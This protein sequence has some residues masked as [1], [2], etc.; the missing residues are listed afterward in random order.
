MNDTFKVQKKLRLRI[1]ES[2]PEIGKEMWIP[3]F[4]MVSVISIRIKIP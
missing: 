1:T 2:L 4:K 3:E